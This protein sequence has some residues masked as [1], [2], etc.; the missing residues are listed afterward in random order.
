MEVAIS[1]SP[2]VRL[3]MIGIGTDL[4]LHALA[5]CFPPSLPSMG[6]KGAGGCEGFRVG[7]FPTHPL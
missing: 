1:H 6:E 7:V 3:L 4:P 5:L 2:E